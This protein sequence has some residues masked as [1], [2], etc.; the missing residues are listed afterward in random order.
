MKRV[1]LFLVLFGGGLYLLM[2]F[3]QKQKAEL[4]E[5]LETEQEQ[6]S[7]GT[8]DSSVP[9][10]L[11]PVDTEATDPGESAS[12]GDGQGISIA[13][14]GEIKASVLYDKAPNN[15]KYDILLDNV[16]PRADGYYDVTGVHI[17]SFDEKGGLHVST[18]D[19]VSGL[20]RIERNPQGKLL[21]GHAERIQLKT[22][23]VTLERGFPMAPVTI[24]LPEAE[25]DLNT[26]SLHSKSEVTIT[27]QGGIGGTG[28]GLLL[29]NRGQSSSL[30]NQ[31]FSILERGELN[32]K[33]NDKAD[34]QLIA[35]PGSSI[36]FFRATTR[37]GSERLELNMPK[38]GRMITYG[39]NS[40][41]VSG[42]NISMIG[43]MISVESKTQTST[44]T[45][46]VFRPENA[47]II[48]DSSFQ[49]GQERVSGGVADVFF[50]AKGTVS[51]LTMAK[52][53]VLSGILD[54]DFDGDGI[55]SPTPVTVRG[56][57]PMEFDYNPTRPT[58]EFNL[59][60]PSFLDA[61]EMNFHLQAS[62]GIRGSFWGPG[63]AD[64]N[65]LGKVEGNFED[66]TFKGSNV[67]LRGSQ[68]PD[69]PKHLYFETNEPSHL[70]GRNAKDE[71]VDLVT[72]GQLNLA[73]NDG[74][75]RVILAERV[76]LS[77]EGEKP[78]TARVGEL[79]DFDLEAKSFSADKDVEFTGPWGTGKGKR[80]VRYS[81]EHFQLFGE[82]G[83]LASFTLDPIMGGRLDFGT[84]HAR[85]IELKSTDVVAQGDV[86]VRLKG[87]EG[88]QELD[89]AQF[90]IAQIGDRVDGK[91]T[92]FSFEA[93]QVTRGV[94]QGVGSNSTFQADIVSGEGTLLENPGVKPVLDLSSMEASGGVNLNYTGKGGVFTGK[95]SRISWTKDG[96]SR[97]EANAGSRVEARG[98]FEEDGL[99]YILTATWIEFDETE[100]QALFP[101]FALDRPA[102]LP[103][104][105]GGRTKTELHSGSAEWMTADE[106]GLLLAGKAHF[107]GKTDKGQPIDLD[108]GSMHV[109]RLP[110]GTSRTQG[111]DELVAWDGFRLRVGK[112]L[113]GTGEILEAG[114]RVMRM[115]G[116]PATLGVQGFIWES[117][118]I[119]YDVQ[120]VL[121]TAEQGRLTGKLGAG[122]EQWVATYESLQPF[123]DDDSTVMV[124]RNP[125]VTSGNREIRANWAT[126]WLDRQEWLTKTQLWLNGEDPNAV[127]LPRG[128]E[129]EDR[130]PEAKAPT[131]FGRFDSASISKV[132]K[133]V[134]YEGDIEYLVDGH[135]AGR[136]QAAYVDMLDGHGW[137]QDAEMFTQLKIGSRRTDLAIRA[138][139][140]R[141]SADGS[142][143]ADEATVTSCGFAEPHYSISTKNLRLTPVGERGTVWD[144]LLRD[145]SLV[146]D[147]GISIPLPRVHYNSDGKGRPNFSGLRFGDSA[148]YGSFLEASVDLEG[149]RSMKELLAAATG[150]DKEKVRSRYRLKASIYGSRGLLLDQRLRI[151]AA[152]K[153]WANV[154]LEGLSDAGK[155]RG[156][157]RSK[158]TGSEHL[159]WVFTT[160]S[161]Y[162]LDT[163]EWF[164]FAFTTQSDAG[165]QA[166]FSEGQFVSYERRDNFLRWR[167][168]KDQH[169]YSAELRTRSNSFHSEVERLPDLGYLRGLTPIGEIY[170][171]PLLYTA[172][173]EAGYLRSRQ[174][175]GDVISPF[176]PVLDPSI[177]NQ[178]VLRLDT[179][180]RVEA[181]FDLGAFGIRVSPFVSVA[182]SMW[183][184]G[185]EEDTAPSRGAA[186]LGVEAQS[187]FYRTWSHGVVNMLTPSAGIRGNIAEFDEDGAPL[188]LD[189]VD[190]PLTGR[191]VDLGLRSRWRVPGGT[192]FVDVAV[193]AT[194][195]SDQDA[196]AEDRWLPALVLGD[197]LGVIEKI[198]FA[199]VHDANYDMESG[200]SGRTFTALSLLPWRDVGLELAYNRG[201]ELSGELLYDAVSFGARWDATPKWQFEARQSLSRLSNES[202]SN[203]FIFRRISHDFVFELNYGFRSGEG[204]NSISI[205]YRPLV[206]W[207]P[208]TFGRMQTLQSAR[209]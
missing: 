37:E 35:G 142:L 147:N 4:K 208:G 109:L 82:E 146:F 160:Q 97:L 31:T 120:N 1:L 21:I 36:D 131:L 159:R 169:Y 209:L 84:L 176:D 122:E 154:Y 191:F 18:F 77:M 164:D 171:Q 17:K 121:I 100:L 187:T 79:R 96:R 190:D 202:L 155:D 114:Y 26:D 127:V 25:L 113:V 174:A 47:H 198:P 33:A 40:V 136:M 184:R 5:R 39:E 158:L 137:I 88:E 23:T 166:E 99:P 179:R 32:M 178:D 75:A 165:V 16:Q 115:E 207:R 61:E 177:G 64:I 130:L 3:S 102:A 59:P 29:S 42:R 44:V 57:G 48:G 182:G 193:R 50:D 52:K 19:A 139:W 134:Y 55:T 89:C 69:E 107:S 27:G 43:R 118:N 72:K 188:R 117:N 123:A 194:H 128:P 125:T 133:E 51:R 103:Q 9:F 196:G 98:R 7:K 192:R 157:M 141:H 91:P 60:G 106:A 205:K 67:N 163:Q 62:T 140:L 78:M 80:A 13:L 15:K 185:I 73:V 186:I 172:T 156:L 111:I 85:D 68:A 87:P 108:A 28:R 126:F 24:E 6:R 71:V 83:A 63:S 92:K 153:F 58:A 201:E 132:L 95:G 104:I 200:E 2:H 167:K 143:T 74:N 94:F 124:M 144:I 152:D 199:V 189:H 22:V 197:V 14:G 173:A 116:R 148:R 149:G 112:E 183:S 34:V 49:R 70:M 65:L 20:L 81:E 45:K 129:P 11:V 90:K 206:G 54:F 168:A 86:R 162:K 10:T 135:L 53:P 66:K 175:E 76:R 145:N 138:D 203:S 170:G 195:A 110:E 41:D 46:Q 150:V 180:H 30:L 38:G 119:E 8:I 105:L 93:K 101:E 161:R 204:G 151:T 181:P 56:V 12:S